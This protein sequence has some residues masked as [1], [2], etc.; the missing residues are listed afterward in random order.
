MDAQFRRKMGKWINRAFLFLIN[1]LKISLFTWIYFVNCIESEME[2]NEFIR[3]YC[4]VRPSNSKESTSI[5]LVF[6]RILWLDGKKCVICESPNIHYT[7]DSSTNHNFI[8][9]SVFDENTT[10]VLRVWK[11]SSSRKTSSM[12]LVKILPIIVYKVIM[13]VY[14]H[15][16]KLVQERHILF[17]DHLQMMV[18]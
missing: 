11:T 18:S 10:Q 1:C 7:T 12:S 14:L 15:M 6:K 4:R 8:F 3:V 2:N 9:D 16:V 5:Y 13:D 17:W